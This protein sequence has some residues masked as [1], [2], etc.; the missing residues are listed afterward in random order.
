MNLCFFLAVTDLKDRLRNSLVG[1][2]IIL[3]SG[4]YMTI[5]YMLLKHMLKTSILVHE[6]GPMEP[7]ESI[8]G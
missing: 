5:L 4:L 6:F 2:R 3:K 8:H 7:L 1:S